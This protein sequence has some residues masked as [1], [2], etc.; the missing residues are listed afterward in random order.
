MNSANTPLRTRTA[1]SHGLRGALQWRLWLLWIVV[2]GICALVGALPFWN[3]L[4]GVLDNS[5]LAGVVGSGKA[6]ALMLEA[7]M[8]RD[9]PLGLLAGGIQF[10]TILML[11]LTPLLT[12]ST[13]AAARSQVTLGFGDL[14]RGGI[15]EYGPMLRMLI[16]SV[17]PLGIA[18]A[19]MMGIMAANASAHEHAVLA[20]ELDTGRNI[21]L[22]V[23]GIL[24]VLAHASLEAGRGW[25]AADA[26]LRSALKAWWRGLKLLL[27]RPFAVLSVYLITTLG[28]LLLAVLMIGVRQ[29][30]DAT[31]GM[32]F[33]LAI[34]AGFGITTALALSRI[35]RLFGMQSLAQDMHA[36]R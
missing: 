1:L 18:V 12:G 33:V 26:R 31:T 25:L 9:A 3:W 4:G 24:W 28:G 27:R 5:L 32:G 19:A 22:I 17:I 36:R 34:L 10:A 29:H 2:T 8:S 16:W 30:I 7:L 14:L 23:G 15:G 6:P 21:A 13:V 20:S 11:L 35:A